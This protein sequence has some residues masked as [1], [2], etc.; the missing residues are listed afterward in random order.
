MLWKFKDKTNFVCYLIRGKDGYK[1]GPHF[2]ELLC[3]RKKY[4]AKPSTTSRILGYQPKYH[5]L[6][7]ICD[8]YP[9]YFWY[10]RPTHKCVSNVFIELLFN[11]QL[12]HNTFIPTAI[13]LP[14][15]QYIMPYVQYLWLV[16][17]L[18]L[19]KKGFLHLSNSI[20]PLFQIQTS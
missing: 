15:P 8:W 12:K 13:G 18:L 17:C 1:S 10:Y 4:P 20:S 7:T 9:A 2:K 19:L 11:K 14:I 3:K 6:C 16:S 5:V